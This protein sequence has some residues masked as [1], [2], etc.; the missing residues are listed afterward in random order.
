M[1]V[2]IRCVC[3]P[4][5]DGS[6]R[7]EGDTVTLR[8]T[9]GFREVT[10]IRNLAG[11]VDR[12]DPLYVAEILAALSEGYIVFG[13]ESWTLVDEK[14]KP[15]PVS[16]AAIREHLLADVEVAADVADAADTLY[17]EKVVLPL[18]TRASRSSQP[19]QTASSTSRTK[20]SSEQRPTP[21]KRSSTGSSRTAGTETITT[22][23]DGD[24]SY[25]RSSASVA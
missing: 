3:P 9:L 17:G 20:R 15:L 19:T 12:D 24:S 14:G 21:L 8:D 16:R 1:D 2:P 7:H 5:T 22:S 18:L 23:P 13:V 6:P 11:Q 10:T 25:S 4:K